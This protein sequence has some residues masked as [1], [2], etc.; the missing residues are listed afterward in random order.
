MGVS[1]SEI[2][3]QTFS[4]ITQA[5]LEQQ[6]MMEQLEEENRELHTL[7][8]NLRA[9]QNIF[10]EIEGKRFPLLMQNDA[11]LHEISTS[12]P[13]AMLPPVEAQP[14]P[15]LEEEVTKENRIVTV[16]ADVTD[17]TDAP[18]VAMLEVESNYIS[19][20]EY[21][22]PRSVTTAQLPRIYDEEEEDQSKAVYTPTFLEE[23]MLDEFAAAATSPMA[24]WTGPITP[25]NKKQEPLSMSDEE[26]KATLRKE[27]LGSFLLD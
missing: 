20:P 17:V 1:S 15:E 21:E 9:G 2:I 7:L 27:L 16:V 5:V 18:T 6:K 14:A 8:T 23:V 24:V 19:E 26:K 22:M 13:V 10:L 3:I 12:I 11:T 4:E 25:V